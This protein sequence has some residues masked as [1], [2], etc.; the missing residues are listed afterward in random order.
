[1]GAEPRQD[2]RICRNRAAGS[3]TASKKAAGSGF[4]ISVVAGQAN[5]DQIPARGYITFSNGEQSQA[6][7]VFPAEWFAETRKKLGR[8]RATP[9]HVAR[10][11]HF[12]MLGK[13]PVTERQK[14]VAD[15]FGMDKG[16]QDNACRAVRRSVGKAKKALKGYSIFRFEPSCNGEKR[17]FLAIKGMPGRR[18]V[19]GELGG[20]QL[21]I[22]ADCWFCQFG[23]KRAVQGHVKRCIDVCD[24]SQAT[25]KRI[26]E[27]TGQK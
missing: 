24:V 17:S 1:M 9:L 4:S 26:G 10:F 19:D 3:M 7:A 5:G 2:R 20:V 18:P 12:R 21:V 13:G 16:D 6:N 15:I 14:L 11:A 23:M 8:K 27:P 25:L 22:D